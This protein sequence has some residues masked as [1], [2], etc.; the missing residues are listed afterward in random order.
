M[1]VSLLTFMVAITLVSCS[2]HFRGDDEIYL[3]PNQFTGPVFILFNQPNGEHLQY[4]NG[5]RIYEIPP[6]GILLT[7]DEFNAGWRYPGQFFYVEKDRRI[8]VP[9]V[10]EV[11]NLKDDVIQACCVTSGRAAKTGNGPWVEYLQFYVGTKDQIHES[12]LK[13]ERINPADF[14]K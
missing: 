8:E 14:I 12:S 13:R 7:R 5:K 6:D 1:R 3:I 4:E 2:C 10:L 9:F 11:H